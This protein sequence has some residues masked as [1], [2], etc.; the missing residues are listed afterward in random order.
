MVLL[1]RNFP[2]GLAEKCKQ[3]SREASTTNAVRKTL[4]NFFSLIPHY[5]KKEL[6]L[7]EKNAILEALIHNLKQ[8]EKAE[9]NIQEIISKISK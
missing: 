6:E 3:R 2:D 5:Q 4:E 1:D 7:Q 8:K 9:K